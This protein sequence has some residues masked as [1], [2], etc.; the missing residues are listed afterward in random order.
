MSSKILKK[1]TLREIGLDKMAIRKACEEATPKLEDGKTLASKGNTV[2]LATFIGSVTQVRPGEV[3]D[4]G[5]PF[6]KLVGS[7]EATNLLTGE[8]FT[9]SPVL[10]L[11]NFVGDGIADA[12]MRGG[13]QAVDF[14]VCITARY[15][16]KA[17]V[18]YEFGAES[19][20]PTQEADAV[21]AIK[22]K[23]AS[24]GIAL[25][26]PKEVPQLSAPAAPAAPAPAAPTAPAPAP[27]APASEP[28]KGKGKK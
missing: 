1:I 14:A 25:P 4:T 5:Q 15:D 28:A 8:V 23:L 3:K 17:A 20:L 9:N 16:E 18:G 19:L 21:S 7:F 10:I 13:A 26:A 6:A 2:K 11:P 22:A 12:V 27:A 24:A